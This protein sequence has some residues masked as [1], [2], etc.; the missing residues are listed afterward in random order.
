MVNEKQAVLQS[1]RYSIIENLYSLYWSWL[2]FE[3]RQK[4]K[5]LYHKKTLHADIYIHIHVKSLLGNCSPFAGSCY[6]N[7]MHF[8]F[9]QFPA[10]ITSD[11]SIG[12]EIPTISSIPPTPLL[13]W[14]S[15]STTSTS[16][17]KSCLYIY[18]FLYIIYKVSIYSWI[19]DPFYIIDS[20]DRNKYES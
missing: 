10:V 15:S 6:N 19:I 14:I 2:I 7:R 16:E 8:P 17:A 1:A 5:V 20:T 3:T 12:F 13:Y 9:V 4:H 18:I 11:L